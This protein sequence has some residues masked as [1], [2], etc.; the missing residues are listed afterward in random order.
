MQK[1]GGGGI[2]RIPPGVPVP[3]KTARF[4]RASPNEERITKARHRE[5]KEALFSSA[6]MDGKH[7]RQ[8]IGL[9]TVFY[10]TPHLRFLI[11]F[12]AELG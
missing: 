7:E 5:K 4:A 10:L 1:K 9:V 2:I 8:L 12:Q 3:P 11:A 6:N